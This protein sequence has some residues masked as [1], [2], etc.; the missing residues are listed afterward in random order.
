MEGIDFGKAATT[1][2]GTASTYVK[3][4]KLKTLTAALDTISA[5]RA[6]TAAE[7][8]KRFE[9]KQLERKATRSR[10][11]GTREAAEERRKGKIL[12]SNV[13]AAMAG[14]GTSTTDVGA[15]EQLA[16]VK[17][18]TD[19]NALA[20]LFESETEA[21]DLELAGEAR[22]FEGKA[23][24]SAGRKKGLATVLGFAKGMFPGKPGKV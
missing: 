9:A 20:A 22:R 15:V 6:G 8:G 5:V 1:A 11:R 17:R 3:G 16:D 4:N 23:A 13:R 7:K 12:A 24:K 19:Y 18:V 21:K 14:S 10:A 2:F